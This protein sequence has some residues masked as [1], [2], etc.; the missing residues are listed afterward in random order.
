[1]SDLGKKGGNAKP[2][3]APNRM[4]SKPSNR[5]SAPSKRMQGKQPGGS[6]A[7]KNLPR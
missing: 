5:P 6:G 1:M 3:G 7:N 4:N 2:T